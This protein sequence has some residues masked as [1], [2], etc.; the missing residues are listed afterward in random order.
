MLLCQFC[1]KPFISRMFCKSR[2]KYCSKDCQ[3]KASRSYDKSL[4]FN[5]DYV[6]LCCSKKFTFPR[7]QGV[8]KYCSRACKKK[9][10]AEGLKVN[11]GLMDLTGQVFGRL[12]VLSRAG[13]IYGTHTAWLCECSCP[14]KTQK[15]ITAQ[16]L[17][18]GRSKSCGCLARGE[19]LVKPTT[20]VCTKCGE[21]KPYDAENFRKN[22]GH[23][24]FGLMAICKTCY[25]PMARKLHLAYRRKLKLEVLTH[26]SNGNL[27]C[28]CP[29]CDVTHIEFLSLDHI[30][31]DGKKDREINGLGIYFYARM[32]RLGYPDHLQVLCYNCNLA[33]SM[34]GQCPHQKPVTVAGANT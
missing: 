4:P 7:S 23:K 2:A 17:R 1:N 21:E 24:R 10:W 32:K 33:K 19:G 31:N 29:G 16:S 8:R 28:Q 30:N 9:H 3:K 15:V 6:C 13:H 18:N 27:K 25:R 14:A 26:Y 11:T 5:V 22:K 20:K 34:F 12:T